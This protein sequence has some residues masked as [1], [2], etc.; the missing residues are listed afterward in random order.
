MDLMVSRAIE[1]MSTYSRVVTS[2]AT[3]H[4]PVV[5]SVS[6][7]T[8]PSGSAARMASR[9]ASD[10]W[11]AILSGWPSVTDSEVKVQRGSRLLLWV[12]LWLVLCLFVGPDPVYDQPP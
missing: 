8:R 1:G 4:R 9:T 2:P 6:Q 10:T 7:A 5:S 11:S 3:T 12:V